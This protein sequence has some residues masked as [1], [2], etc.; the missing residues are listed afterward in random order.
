M[1]RRWRRSSLA[2]P[3]TVHG[4]GRGLY[5]GGAPVEVVRRLAFVWEEMRCV[6]SSLYTPETTK[7][8]WN[9]WHRHY[10]VGRGRRRPL[11]RRGIAINVA[12]TA[13]ATPA[14]VLVRLRR[15]IEPGS[16][17]V[18]TDET[19]ARRERTLGVFVQRPLR[20]IRDAYLS[21]VCISA[22]R[23]IT[24]HRTTEPRNTF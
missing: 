17:L 7:G 4:K 14:P 22:D 11:S 5:G 1:S 19:S 18:G 20:R 10:F 2:A 15:H 23:P 16:L 13:E 9:A 12:Q 24:M 6:R 3:G 8:A 21:Q